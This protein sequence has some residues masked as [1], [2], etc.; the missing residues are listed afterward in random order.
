MNFWMNWTMKNLAY[1]IILLLLASTIAFSQPMKMHERMLTIK[2]VKL[3]EYMD[4]NET[5]SDKILVIVTKYENE[6]RD[7]NEKIKSL[8]QKLSDDIEKL[9]ENDLKKRNDELYNNLEKIADIHKNKLN[10]ARSNLNEKEFAKFQIFELKF[11]HELRK[12]LFE[13][14]KKKK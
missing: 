3:L 11:A 7:L 4:L 14:R 6:L 2:K 9:T 10:E 13:N 5:K 1:S 8:S 12:H